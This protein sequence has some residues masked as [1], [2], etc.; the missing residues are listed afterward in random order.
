MCHRLECI[1][2]GKPKERWGIKIRIMNEMEDERKVEL[3]GCRRNMML[4]MVETCRTRF[5]ILECIFGVVRKEGKGK[6]T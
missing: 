6:K 4:R 3:V 5:H 2:G 1:I